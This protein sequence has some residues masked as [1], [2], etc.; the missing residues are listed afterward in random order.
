MLSSHCMT[1]RELCQA[2]GCPARAIASEMP[3]APSGRR[4]A[5]SPDG[6]ANLYAAL[7]AGRRDGGRSRDFHD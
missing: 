7:D 1:R 3:G 5:N 2:H 6:R 4:W